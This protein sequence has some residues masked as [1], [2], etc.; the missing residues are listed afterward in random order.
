MI[1]IEQ[2]LNE[3]T[4]QRIAQRFLAMT[5]YLDEKQRRLLAGAEALSYGEGG[6][7]RVAALVDMAPATVQRGMRE[8]QNPDSIE[9]ERV[10]RKGGGRK[11]KLASD[12][13]LAT[14]L[15]RL[16]SPATR[17]HPESALL[18]TC[19][20]L[21][22]LADELNGMKSG[23]KVSTHWVRTMLLRAGYS[24]QGQPKDARRRGPSGS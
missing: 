16:I 15:D 23:R 9:P 18:W 6:A 20:S 2:R 14:D 24:L 19:K 3:M 8:L 22:T 10:R 17:G 1:A 12:P 7:E 21:C 4:E 13:E 11:P 5:P